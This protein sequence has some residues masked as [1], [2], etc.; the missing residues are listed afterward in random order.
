MRV[1]ALR[2][3]AL[4]YGR[5][6]LE[7][8]RISKSATD[9]RVFVYSPDDGTTLE[10]AV[11]TVPSVAASLPHRTYLVVA[12]LPDAVTL[13]PKCRGSGKFIATAVRGRVD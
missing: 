12:P 8:W 1:P 13:R 9:C 3:K 7:S 4:I 10:R 2:A 5:N 11:E 6:L